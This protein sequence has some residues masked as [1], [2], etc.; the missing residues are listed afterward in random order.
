MDAFGHPRFLLIAHRFFLIHNGAVVFNVDVLG[1]TLNTGGRGDVRRFYTSRSN[2]NFTV[3][4]VTT[5]QIA[6]ET[7]LYRASILGCLDA[8]DHDM[9]ARAPVVFIKPRWNTPT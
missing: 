3:R 9:G 1:T 8:N 2:L 4:A 5:D 6:M 7:P